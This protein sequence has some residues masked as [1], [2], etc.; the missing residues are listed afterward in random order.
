M[1]GRGSRRKRPS[2]RVEG[3][4]VALPWDV[5]DSAAYSRLSGSAVR[6]LLELGRQFVRDN[7]G[8]L[9]TSMAHLSKRGWTSAGTVTNAVRELE[10]AGFIHQTVKGHRP[11]KASWWAITWQTLDGIPG[12]DPGAAETF[13]RGAYRSSVNAAL[14]P[15]SGATASPIAPKTGAGKVLPMPKTGAMKGTSTTSSTPKTGN[16]LENHLRAESA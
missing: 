9:L 15:K 4:F 8:R 6:L 1:N 11:N 3:G 13:R 2:G 16:H 14:I 7:N 5:L 10:A 12:Y